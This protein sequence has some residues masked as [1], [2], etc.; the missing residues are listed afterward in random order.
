MLT[1]QESEDFKKAYWLL[2]KVQQSMADRGIEFQCG[3]IQDD[4]YYIACAFMELDNV[5]KYQEPVPEPTDAPIHS[6]SLIR[7]EV[8]LRDGGDGVQA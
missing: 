1:K 2:D 6:M 5:E 7:R 8:A 4:M 3:E